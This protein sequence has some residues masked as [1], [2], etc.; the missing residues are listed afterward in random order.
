MGEGLYGR[1]T[2]GLGTLR[3]RWLRRRRD[4]LPAQGRTSVSTGETRPQVRVHT[5]RPQHRDMAPEG[6]PRDSVG[7]VQTGEGER[8]ENHCVHRVVTLEVRHKPR[9]RTWKMVQPVSHRRPGPATRTTMDHRSPSRGETRDSR[10]KH[11]VPPT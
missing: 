6:R 9:K 8:P 1:D 7:G 3:L 2:G 11:S 10:R 5:T 4:P